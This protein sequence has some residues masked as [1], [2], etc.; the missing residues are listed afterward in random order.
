MDNGG[1]G[2]AVVVCVHGTVDVE[3]SAVTNL[4]A[5]QTKMIN[6]HPCIMTEYFKKL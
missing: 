4:A 5:E 2:Y 1:Y 3:Y 6:M